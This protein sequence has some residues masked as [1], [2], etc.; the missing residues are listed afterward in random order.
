[1]ERIR[2]LVVDDDSR[3]LETVRSHLSAQTDIEVV[4][5]ARS[6]TEAAKRFAELRPDVVI[7]DVVMPGSDGIE[8]MRLIKAMDAQ[9]RVLALS[10]YDTRNVRQQ[11]FAAGACSF[12]SK[13]D[14][15]SRLLPEIRRVASA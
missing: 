7:M 8:G 2:I 12:V 6:G 4:G 11:S 1:M 15:T 9:A 10:G 14:A 13:Y 5:D 3:F